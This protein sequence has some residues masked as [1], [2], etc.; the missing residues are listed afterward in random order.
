MRHDYLNTAMQEAIALGHQTDNLG[1]DKTAILKRHRCLNPRPGDVVDPDFVSGNPFF[2]ARDLVQVKYEM[3]RRVE[4]DDESAART[5]AAFGLSRP[6]FYNAMRA[7]RSEGVEGLAARPPGPR[8][9]HKLD[10]EIMAFVEH[11]LAENDGIRLLDIAA[12][13]K[14]AFGV[15]VHPRSIER[16]LKRKKSRNAHPNAGTGPVQPMGRQSDSEHLTR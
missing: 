4:R 7:F 9:P 6:S 8:G 11:T 16:A 12:S 13:I 10:E 15:S 5:S 14:D 2:D 1:K 3:L